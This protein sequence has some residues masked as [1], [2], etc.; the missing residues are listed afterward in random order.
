[1]SL[2]KVTLTKTAPTVSLSKQGG[3][4]RL[5]VNLNWNAQGAGG[6]A[7]G[8][9]L[10]RV[11][12][13]ASGG[14]DLDLAAL[15]ELADGRKGVVQAL[16]NT[17]GSFD[18]PPYVQ[19]DADDRTGAA[20]GGENLF[21]NLAH[22]S[23]IRRLLVFAFIY[24]GAP[25]FDQANAV[26]TLTPAQGAPIEVRLDERGGGA[27]M[28]AIALLTN[29]GNDFVVSREMRYVG[30]HQELDQAYGWG[31]NWTAGRK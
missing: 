29:Q 21:V 18:S 27:R 16:G 25:A 19:L 10:K 24:S 30:G 9:F 2:S 4:G 20:V 17:F 1:V 3:G 15:F 5:H 14:I 12:G 23:Q 13:A 26:V 31:L 6:Q 11:L 7:K 28:C 22:A 8:G